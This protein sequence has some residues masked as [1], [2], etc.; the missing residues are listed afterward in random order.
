MPRSFLVKKVKLD[1]FS[2]AADLE[3]AYRHRTD[4]SLRLHDKGRSCRL[5]PQRALTGVSGAS[6]LREQEEHRQAAQQMK[7]A[8]FTCYHLGIQDVL[9]C[10][11]Q[12]ITVTH[13][14]L[15]LGC[16]VACSFISH[17]TERSSFPVSETCRS[18]RMIGSP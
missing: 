1:D 2:S 17:S 8:S 3:N 4:L 18:E 9:I 15:L 11:K 7:L 13:S 14:E 5:P 12:K 10:D 6:R 16:F